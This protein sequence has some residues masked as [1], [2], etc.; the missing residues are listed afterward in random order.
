MDELQQIDVIEK[1]KAHLLEHAPEL[2][3]QVNDVH[4]VA[5]RRES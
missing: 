4:H 2:E 1:I 5:R 3:T